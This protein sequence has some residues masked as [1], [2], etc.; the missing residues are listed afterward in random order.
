MPDHYVV[1]HVPNQFLRMVTTF[2]QPEMSISNCEQYNSLK[3][4]LN[5]FTIPQ[6]SSHN[7]KSHNSNTHVALDEGRSR[8]SS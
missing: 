8:Q 3:T 6:K 4:M 1:F 2:S 5:I 7:K